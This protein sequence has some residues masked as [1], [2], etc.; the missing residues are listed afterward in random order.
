ML[1]RENGLRQI[2]AFARE[3]GVTVRTLHLYDRVGLLKPAATSEAGYRL[4]GEAE[5]Q[6]LEQILASRFIGF[7]LAQIKQLLAGSEPPFS[8]ALA[9]QREAI[10]RQIERLQSALNAIEAA[11]KAL[12]D[13]RA[14]LWQTL[15]TIIEVFKMENDWQWVRKYYS[16]E[17]WAKV[18][19]L[20]RETPREAIER[21]QRDWSE[22]LARVEEAASRGLDPSSDDA[23]ALAERWRSLLAQFTRGNADIQHGVNRLWSDPTHWPSD[24]KKPWS[25]AAEA[26]IMKAMGCKTKE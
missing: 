3:A 18:E 22:L 8:A 21:G 25:D 1:Q 12:D 16:G 7:S 19:E 15:P 4:Y 9:M 6:R 26:F 5:L 2:T 17:A 23:Q 14:H 11:A 10:A 13:D 24:F 20:H